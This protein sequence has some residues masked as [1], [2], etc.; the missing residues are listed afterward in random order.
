MRSNSNLTPHRGLSL[1]HCNAILFQICH[2]VGSVRQAMT[3]LA[4]YSELAESRRE[5]LSR[6]PQPNGARFPL[7]SRGIRFIDGAVHSSLNVSH[8]VAVTGAQ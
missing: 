5:A 1:A 3:Y 8:P 7:R 2:V 4:D 6:R